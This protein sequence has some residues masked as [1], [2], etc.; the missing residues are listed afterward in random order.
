MDRFGFTAVLVTTDAK[1]APML[2]AR[3]RIGMA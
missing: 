2:I 3:S 1:L